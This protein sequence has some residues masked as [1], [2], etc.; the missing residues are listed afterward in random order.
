M[1]SVFLLKLFERFCSFFLQEP[2]FNFYKSFSVLFISKTC[3]ACLDRPIF[4]NILQSWHLK[5][6]NSWNLSEFPHIF[7]WML[8][9]FSAHLSHLGGIFM[10][11]IEHFF[12]RWEKKLSF[13]KTRMFKSAMYWWIWHVKSSRKKTWE[14]LA[15]F[16]LEHP[17]K[18]AKICTKSQLLNA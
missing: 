6:W 2:A 13:W 4:C 17:I 14:L 1:L 7:L 12:L 5:A 15:A 11:Q 18:N 8:S 16:L 9:L 3:K 10:F